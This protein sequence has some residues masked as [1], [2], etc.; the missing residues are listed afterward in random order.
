VHKCS[1]WSAGR[2]VYALI[3]AN[4]VIRAVG[5]M[6]NPALLHFVFWFAD[7]FIIFVFLHLHSLLGDIP[8][9]QSPVDRFLARGRVHRRFWGPSPRPSSSSSL[10]VMTSYALASQ[11]TY[12]LFDCARNVLRKP[13]INAA[14]AERISGPL[15]TNFHAHTGFD[16]RDL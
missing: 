2:A 9:P 3:S 5:S 4:G 6:S 15:G 1:S 16:H 8:N 10:N 13:S 14:T 7:E 12:L 11:S